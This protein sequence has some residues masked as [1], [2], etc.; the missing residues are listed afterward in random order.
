M[1]S[2]VS[3]VGS[4]K[5]SKMEPILNND[6]KIDSKRAKS[7]GRVKGTPNILMIIEII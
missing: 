7:G 4:K 5:V 1:E 2:K 6:T 3:K